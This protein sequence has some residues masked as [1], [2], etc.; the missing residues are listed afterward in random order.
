MPKEKKLGSGSRARSLGKKNS[1]SNRSAFIPDPL[2]PIY[3]KIKDFQ[4][5]GLSPGGG[6]APDLDPNPERRRKKKGKK[7]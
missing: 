4:L 1:T 5:P 3:D 2:R 7:K 6:Y